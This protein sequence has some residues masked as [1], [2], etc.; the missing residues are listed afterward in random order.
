MIVHR[1]IR[2]KL[3]SVGQREA[4]TLIEVLVVIAIIALLITLFLPAVQAARDAARRTV[5][6]N[7]LSQM[8]KAFHL[9]H[10]AFGSFPTGGSGVDTP[11]SLRPDGQIARGADQAWGWAYQVL[12]YLEQEALFEKADD[13]AIKRTA[14]ETYFC[15]SRRGPTVFDVTVKGSVGQRAQTDY[16]GCGGSKDDGVDGLLVRSTY[17]NALKETVKI[18]VVRLPGSVPDGTSNTLLLGE[19][20]INPT[21]F[22]R[23]TGPES[24]EY[25]GGYVTGIPGKLRFLVRS[26]EFLPAFDRPYETPDDFGR[27]GSSHP[28]GLNAV[29]GDGSLRL[30]RYQVSQRVFTA[31]CRRDDGAAFSTADL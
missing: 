6:S 15:P 19:R 1:V 24:D 7:Q 25:R 31:A 4:I 8:G 27:F 29:F 18:A 16:A 10:D 20:Y 12:P 3:R 23:A 30:I 2:M 21:W 28:A 17:E 5:C 9:H 22:N 26:G 14:I 13:E 11:R